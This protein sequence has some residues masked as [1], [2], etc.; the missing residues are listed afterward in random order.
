[1][2]PAVCQK[3]PLFAE[4]DAQQLAQINGIAGRSV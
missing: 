1:M 3:V 4:L 2:R